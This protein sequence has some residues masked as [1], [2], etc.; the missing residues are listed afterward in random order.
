MIDCLWGNPRV[1]G[2]SV[3]RGHKIPDGGRQQE[4]RHDIMTGVVLT[5]LVEGLPVC[6]G[7]REKAGSSDRKGIWCQPKKPS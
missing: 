7:V 2:T 5:G 1:L 3:R 6:E 4:G